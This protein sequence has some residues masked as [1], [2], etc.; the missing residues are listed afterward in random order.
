MARCQGV[1]GNPPSP[2]LHTHT[3]THIHIQDVLCCMHKGW[4]TCHAKGLK[5]DNDLLLGQEEG[6]QTH[7]V[8]WETLDSCSTVCV[9]A[10]VSFMNSFT[11]LR[12]SV[13]KLSVLPAVG[14]FNASATHCCRTLAQLSGCSTSSV[15]PCLHLEL[16]DMLHLAQ[17]H[18]IR[19]SS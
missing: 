10:C 11:F 1:L 3:H 6:A 16:V 8:P 13:R 17:G 2:M 7:R 4:L 5:G 12:I 9:C 15:F 18:F 14:R 19:P